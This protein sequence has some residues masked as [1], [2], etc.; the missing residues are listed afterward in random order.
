MLALRCYS[1]FWLSPFRVSLERSCMNTGLQMAG[2]KWP[3][4]NQ[5]KLHENVHETRACCAIPLVAIRRQKSVKHQSL[6]P[7]P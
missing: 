5:Q 2:K 4:N 6:L 7:S 3:S 1:D